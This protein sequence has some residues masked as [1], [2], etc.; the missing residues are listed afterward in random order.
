MARLTCTI[1][2]LML[3]VMSGAAA[4][5]M[6]ACLEA[7]GAPSCCEKKMPCCADGECNM[8]PDQAMRAEAV[9]DLHRALDYF[10]VLPHLC[11][12]RLVPK[13]ATAP[14][15]HVPQVIRVRGPDL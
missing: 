10:N 9:L 6:C 3:L 1:M 4:V 8:H 12:F 5:R 2:A 15:L 7:L 13:V 14:V 11:A